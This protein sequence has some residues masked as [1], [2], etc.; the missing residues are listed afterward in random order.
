MPRA[1]HP[2]L[3]DFPIALWTTSVIFDIASFW[4]GPVFVQL[5]FWNLVGGLV[6]A[7]FAALAGIRDY[8]RLPRLSTAKKP[9][10]VHAM[11]AVF[12]V[13]A[14]G[15]SL[16]F[17]TWQ[18]DA[19]RTPTGAFVLSL[20]GVTLLLVA[21]KLGG[22]L[23]FEHGANVAT[24]RVPRAVLTEADQPDTSLYPRPGKPVDQPP[25]RPRRPHDPTL[26]S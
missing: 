17:R 4:F 20:I 12:S 1:L 25:P 18:T 13:L 7:V 3:T 6:F 16:W 9:G 21:G 2:P 14:F 19:T 5:A 11:F 10:I 26:H 24:V 8:A 23:V 15:V 22:N